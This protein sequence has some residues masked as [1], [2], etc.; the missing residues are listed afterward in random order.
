MKYFLMIQIDFLLFTFLTSPIMLMR[1]Y[2]W[3]S[4]PFQDICHAKANEVCNI[5]PIESKVNP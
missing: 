1:V 5:K 4:F 3:E 2:N